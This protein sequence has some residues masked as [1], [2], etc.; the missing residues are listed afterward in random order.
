LVNDD[1][2]S[3][4]IAIRAGRRMFENLRHALQYV[5]AVHVPIIGLAALP[6]IPG[7]PSILMPVHVMFFEFVIDPACSVVFEAEP[8][9]HDLMEQAPRRLDESVLSWP[10]MLHAVIDG[11]IALAGVLASLVLLRAIDTDD[12]ELRAAIFAVMVCTNLALIF[13]QRGHYALGRANEKAHSRC[14]QNW[15]LWIVTTVALMAMGVALT[16]PSAREIFHFAPLSTSALAISIA[17]IGLTI[18]M[19]ITKHRLFRRV[20]KAE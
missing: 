7:L 4:V 17:M 3:I 20:V 10:N 13:A 6:L 8:A 5:V 18:V 19:L 15:A 1:F 2:A 11:S 14:P 12:T 9:A 16:L